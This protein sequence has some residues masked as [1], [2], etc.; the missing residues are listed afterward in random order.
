LGGSPIPGSRDYILALVA[1]Y[2]E[3]FVEDRSQFRE[4][5]ATTN[6]TAFV[7]LDLGLWN[8]DWVHFPSDVIQ[9]SRSVEGIAGL[10]NK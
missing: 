3:A 7:M 5:R 10:I 4:D 6:A 2:L 8:A 1:E 9:P